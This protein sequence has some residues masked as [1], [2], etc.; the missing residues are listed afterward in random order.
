MQKVAVVQ[1]SSVIGDTQA[2][3]AKAVELIHEVAA[4]GAELVV[5][6][7]AFVGGYPK[8]DGF[9]TVMGSRSDAGRDAFRDYVEQAIALDGPEIEALAAAAAEAQV[10]VVIGVIERLGETLYCTVAMIDATLG[11]V[12]KH[13]KVMPTG[14]ER[15]IW[16]FGDGST[17]DVVESPVGRVGAAICWEN[18][19]PLLRQAMYAQGVQVYCAPTVDERAVWQNTMTHIALEGRTFVLSACQA[20]PIDAYPAHKKFE[21]NIGESGWVI[22]GGSVI[23]DPLGKV[24]AGPVYEEETVLYA[25]IDLNEKQRG[26]F[27]LDVNGHYGR[28]DIFELHVN[29]KQQSSVVFAS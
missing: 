9:G 3:V 29:T 11:L 6:P 22:R 4:N 16:G 1:A 25:D 14:S 19:M 26:H 5:F 24:L 18:Y 2:T 8:G 15:L 7:E 20:V 23:I 17:L 21:N 13:R 28:P 12:G 10:F 27:D